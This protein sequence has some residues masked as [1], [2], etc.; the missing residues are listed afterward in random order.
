[1]AESSVIPPGTGGGTRTLKTVRSADFES[2]A[3]A[4][5]PLRLSIQ[6]S[7]RAR[8]GIF[9]IGDEKSTVSRLGGPRPGE[10]RL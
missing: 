10:A 7:T 1:M 9:P 4:I 6:F 8:E 2:A 3:F 5:P